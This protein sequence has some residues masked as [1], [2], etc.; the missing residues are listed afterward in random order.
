MPQKSHRVASRQAAVSK[1]RKHKKKSKG[2]TTQKHTVATPSTPTSAADPA[3]PT[4]AHPTPQAR[5]SVTRYQY[6][7]ADLRR[8][9]VIAGTMFAI[10]IMLSFVL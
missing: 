4:A 10:L 8:I 7:N 5:Q 9:A 2:Q 1:E 6:V 3:V